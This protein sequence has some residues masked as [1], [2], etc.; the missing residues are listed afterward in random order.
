MNFNYSYEK[1][2]FDKEWAKLEVEY[3]QAGMPNENIAKMKEFD[4]DLFKARR[5]E[6]LHTQEITES[7]CSQDDCGDESKSTL[8]HKFMD[9][10]SNT[11]DNSIHHSRYWWIEELESEKLIGNIKNLSKEE[12]EILTLYVFYDKTQQEIAQLLG[13]TQKAISRRIIKI[14]GILKK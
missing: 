13:M 2:Q 9:K 1:K 11:L 7:N 8:L 3:R 12:L 5:I 4:W 6:T 10:L 14:R